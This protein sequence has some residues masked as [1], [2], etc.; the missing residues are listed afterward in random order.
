MKIESIVLGG[1][2]SWC[3]EAVFGMI[4]GVIAVT[5]G[6]AG[7]FKKNPSY[8]EVCAGN[9]G[10]AEVVKIDYDPK[11]VSLE[12]LLGVFFLAHDPTQINRQ[13][14]DVGTQYR[15]IILCTNAKQIKEAKER[16]KFTQ[17]G[18]EGK[19]ATEVK[20]LGEFYAAEDY[21][22]KFFEKNPQHAYCRLVI[23]PKLEKVRKELGS[24]RQ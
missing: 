12:E 9:T 6:Y 20:K 23:S 17:K 13:G 7:G 15:S 21:H 24:R 18:F 1:G 2:C 14:S 19:I 8:E 16:I 22:I 4:K 5:P 10:H 11:S 3:T